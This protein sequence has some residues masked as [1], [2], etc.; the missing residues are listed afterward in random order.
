MPSETKLLPGFALG[1][2]MGSP[3]GQLSKRTEN[4]GNLIESMGNTQTRANLID[5]HHLIGDTIR[6]ST[7]L[8]RLV[9]IYCS[10]QSIVLD[11][12]FDES[13]STP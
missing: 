3:F 6:Y 12:P 10:S 13:D 5:L 9:E 7:I 2:A 8:Q 4:I 11:K 1:V